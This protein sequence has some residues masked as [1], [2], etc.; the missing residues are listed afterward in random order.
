MRRQNAYTV[1][2]VLTT[3]A[4]LCFSTAFATSGVY[5]FQM[6]ELTPLQLVLVGTALEFAVFCFE[7]PTGVV[8][9]L[10]S[11]RLSVITGYLLIG[12][13]IFLEGSFTFFTTILLA[14]LLWG[15]GYTFTSG[16]LDAWLAD[17][18]G[19]DRLPQAYLRGSQLR[20]GASFV[21]IFAGTWLASLRL[22]IP[23]LVGGV[24]MVLV[25]LYLA[26]AMPETNFTPTPRGERSTWQSMGHT[27]MEGMR[28]IR[29]SPLLITILLIALIVGLSS[30]GLDRLWEAHLLD[31][32]ALP[33]I[34]NLEPIYWFALINGSVMLLTIGVTELLRRSSDRFDH[35][36]AV[37]TL[38]ALN[39][40]MIAGL[41]VFGLAQALPL[42]VVAYVAV[43]VARS[44]SHPVFSAWANRGIDPK[45]RATVL[46]TI[47][48][49]DAVGQVAGGPPVG[50]IG[51]SFWP[52]CRHGDRSRLALAGTGAVG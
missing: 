11:R 49:A 15:V 52:A 31:S 16:A 10:Y 32:F 47:G 44:A 51:Q 7:I 34:G 25:A 9:D 21:G 27:F 37:W 20:Q 33:G 19:E 28:F 18:I 26:I 38:I 1:Y 43:S 41:I 8:A 17:E 2:L 30:E 45:V 6:A 39:A 35:R 42:A 29:R 36:H 40:I 5:R 4:A 46:S 22:N 12:A 48:Q 50:M 3:A 23:F 14:Q 24:A 13:G